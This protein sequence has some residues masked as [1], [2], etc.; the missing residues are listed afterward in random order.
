MTPFPF[1]F[2][3]PS[4]S[5]SFPFVPFHFHPGPLMPRCFAVAFPVSP[6]T[7]G[8]AGRVSGR[9]S[10]KEAD[11]GKEADVNASEHLTQP[12]HRD[13]MATVGRRKRVKCQGSRDESKVAASR[14]QDRN[15]NSR[16]PCK[17]KADRKAPF[18]AFMD[19][20]RSVRERSIFLCCC[21]SYRAFFAHAEANANARVRSHGSWLLSFLRLGSS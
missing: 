20:H 4:L 2:Q 16:R 11:N 21:H 7:C 12:L 10:E 15:G 5:L 18:F 3:F 8:E 9:R 13:T 14:K 17:C 6:Y 19:I 1:P